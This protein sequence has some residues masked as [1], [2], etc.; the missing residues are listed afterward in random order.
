MLVTGAARLDGASLPVNLDVVKLPSAHRAEL[1]VGLPEGGPAGTPRLGLWGVR[2]ALLTTLAR[3]TAPDLVF[4]DHA[5]T[6][7]LAE[8]K[9]ALYTLRRAEPCPAFVLGLPDIVT[10]AAEVERDWSWTGASLALDDLYDRILVYGDRRIYD[11]TVEYRFSA[12]AVR[13][14]TFCGYLPAPQPT[15][16]P[17]KVRNRLRAT[18]RPLVLVTTGGGEDGAPLLDAFLGVLERGLLRDVAAFVTTGPYLEPG[19]RAAVETR[20]AGRSN[21]TVV[22]FA[23]DLIDIV[24]AANVVVTMGGY[25]SV[26]DVLAFGKRP[27]VVPRAGNYAEH[28]IRAASLARLG[29][30][31]VVAADELTPERLAAAIQAELTSDSSPPRMLEFN[32]LRRVVD[33]LVD[34][35]DRRIAGP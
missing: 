21:L 10:D 2:S 31:T 32:G 18:A 34:L 20:A 1:Y 12:A 15:A 9:Q 29:L 13:K 4:V 16:S 11:P 28:R 33:V 6:G 35:L 23:D 5:P 7:P 17:A 19:E 26:R 30:A 27:I 14:T 8:L 22:T 3:V 25:G 24:Q